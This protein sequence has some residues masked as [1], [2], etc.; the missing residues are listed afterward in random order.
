M[1]LDAIEKRLSRLEG[2][3]RKG[4]AIFISTQ[5]EKYEDYLVEAKKARDECSG[6]SSINMVPLADELRECLERMV[7]ANMDEDLIEYVRE[8]LAFREEQDRE[9]QNRLNFIRM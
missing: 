5:F 4:R 2:R 1:T 3:E 8:E 9:Y 7:A 6:I